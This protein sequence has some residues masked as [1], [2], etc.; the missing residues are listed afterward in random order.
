MS[1][2]G[3]LQVALPGY[4]PVENDIRL[5][6]TRMIP[7]V[8]ATC[9]FAVGAATRTPA[10]NGAH[11]LTPLGNHVAGCALPVPVVT[12]GP[13]Q[14]TSSAITSQAP[15]LSAGLQVASAAPVAVASRCTSVPACTAA[16]GQSQGASCRTVAV[17][18][19]DPTEQESDLMERMADGTF[20]GSVATGSV[21]LVSL[22]C[23]CGPKLSFKDIGRGAETLPFDWARTRV[24]A[25][26]TFLSTDFEGFFDTACNKVQYSDENGTPWTAFRSAIHSF[27]H[28]DPFVP[29]MRER[30]TRRI[31][32]LLSIDARSSPVLFVRSVAQTTEILRTGELLGLL[33]EKFGPQAKLLLIV[34]FQG[35]AAAGPC[36]VKG[37]E[38]LLIYFFDTASAASTRAPYAKPLALALNWVTGQPTTVGLLPDLHTAHAL[39][40]PSTWGMY[41]AAGVPAFV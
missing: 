24:E 29:A 26:L 27:W 4:A 3:C 22:G 35:A 8:N 19:M 7:V 18:M 16:E 32:R 14:Y 25:L 1:A 20:A 33:L 23:S 38:N 9:S 6:T 2:H 30:Y 13:S 41:G 36:V 40:Q 17:T 39:A 11:P 21:P 37:V 5:G 10:I 34:D 31:N 15:W 28:D 12:H